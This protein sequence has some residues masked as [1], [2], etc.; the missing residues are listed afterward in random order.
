MT[1]KEKII[2]ALGE[3]NE[4]QLQEVYQYIQNLSSS[5]LSLQYYPKSKLNKKST[6]RES[7]LA[8]LKKIAD[9]AVDD[10]IEPKDELLSP[11]LS[12][13]RTELL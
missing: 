10:E 4:N 1:I 8:R 6:N 2:A 12:N 5:N 11:N 7:L 3:L 9:S 13:F